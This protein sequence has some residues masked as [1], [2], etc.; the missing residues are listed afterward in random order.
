MPSDLRSLCLVS[1]DMSATATPALYRVIILDRNETSCLS[2]IMRSSG[3]PFI[4]VI[5][6][7]H[8]NQ[9]TFNNLSRLIERL[10]KDSLTK[11]DVGE[12]TSSSP[13]LLNDI[14]QSQKRLR[15][16]RWRFFFEPER[17]SAWSTVAITVGSLAAFTELSIK[18]AGEHRLGRPTPGALG[19][20]FD[21]ANLPL[22]PSRLRKLKIEGSS[23]I[24]DMR[25]SKIFP[26]E[27]FERL[28]HLTLYRV[29]F[30]QT[31]RLK[32]NCPNLEHLALV[33]CDMEPKCSWL[34]SFTLKSMF[35][36]Y[37]QE[38]SKPLDDVQGLVNL[39][40]QVCDLEVLAV[41]TKA[42][43]PRSSKKLAAAIGRHT[44]SLT[45]L[46][47]NNTWHS[48]LAEAVGKCE[49]L[50][51]LGLFF[52]GL[53]SMTEFCEVTDSLV[54]SVPISNQILTIWAGPTNNPSES[55]SLCL[56]HRRT[57]F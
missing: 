49:A 31:L 3:L 51:T 8:C 11:C 57:R 5:R 12:W 47:V 24:H 6:I 18:L 26:T 25:L 2:R 55:R 21:G 48:D 29:F 22:N 46:I 35:Y 53:E 4:R 30:E 45:F 34:S 37:N 52:D 40:N 39:L 7:L 28:T 56:L 17:I 20:K 33:H 38:H 1:K 36:F 54:Q 9:R 32:L 23:G 16:L 13:L 14:W 43:E 42:M 50:C 15:N 27:P 41:R 44:K 19:K 10:P